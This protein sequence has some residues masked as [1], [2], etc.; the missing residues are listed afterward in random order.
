MI[1]PGSR[2]M[3]GPRLCKDPLVCKEAGGWVAGLVIIG[4]KWPVLVLPVAVCFA[5]G[6]WQFMGVPAAVILAPF[7]S[8][9]W[10][11][12]L[13]AVLAGIFY[14]RS[15]EPT[16]LRM[17]AVRSWRPV[18]PAWAV[19]SARLAAGADL[20]AGSH[21]VNSIA[22]LANRNQVPYLRDR[23]TVPFL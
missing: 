7:C 9:F 12:P 19:A 11:V 6:S 21:P 4:A 18:N 15:I 13:L 2:Q 5:V 8:R 3:S 14:P 10:W 17:E 23:S 16:W 1:T 22:H 20:A